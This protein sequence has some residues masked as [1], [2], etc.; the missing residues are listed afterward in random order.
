MAIGQSVG[1][2]GSAVKLGKF[3]ARFVE[4]CHNRGGSSEV[5]SGGGTIRSARSKREVLEPV[6]KQALPPK[7]KTRPSEW[8]QRQ[9]LD[10]ML[11]QLKRGCN[12]GG[13]PKDFPPASTVYGH[14]KQW[15]DA[16]VFDQLLT[17]LHG[18]HCGALGD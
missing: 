17:V 11:Y 18:A 4:R 1:A 2:S 9:R 15:R 12:W 10:G 8:S 16:G 6:L 7:K 14:Y 13:L 5:S 3:T